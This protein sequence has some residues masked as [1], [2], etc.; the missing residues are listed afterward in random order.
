MPQVAK[1]IGVGGIELDKREKELVQQVLDSGRL[2]YGPMSK[3]FEQEFSQLHGCTHGVFCNSGTSALHL[4]LVALA[5]QRTWQPGDEVIIPATTFITTLNVVRLAGFT[6]ILADVQP[7]TFNI[8]PQSLRRKVTPRTR[9]ILPVHLLG[10]PADMDEVL[11]V[12]SAHNLVVIED[13]CEC[14]FA[15]YRGR[16]VGSLGEVACFSTYVSHM[17][18]TGVGGMAITN[19]IELEGIMRSLLNH[20]R[21]NLYVAID[22]DQGLSGDKLQAVVE[23]RYRFVRPGFSY[24]MTE[25]EAAIGIGQLEKWQPM[26]QRRRSIATRFRETLAPYADRIRIQAV[27]E[28]RTH[29]YMAFACVCLGGLQAAKMA[30]SLEENGIETR[31]LFPLLTQ[32][33]YQSW[34]QQKDYPVA[35]ELGHNGFYIGCHP[36]MSDSEVDFVCETL[37]NYLESRQSHA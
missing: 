15:E 25:L 5:E 30:L 22:D 35:A 10:L 19:N 33:A 16:K 28:D 17:I 7:H 31:P 23:S 26:L 34:F 14:M 1:Q 29:S 27:P 11:A 9:C 37:R 32:P 20:G 24:R 3:R 36:Y 6:P 21:D 4:A 18:A 13:S 12:S 2:S 8:D